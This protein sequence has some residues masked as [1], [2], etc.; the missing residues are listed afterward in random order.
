MRNVLD[1]IVEKIK[2]HILCSI[3][4]LEIVPFVR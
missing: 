4:L 1:R 3:T 2:M